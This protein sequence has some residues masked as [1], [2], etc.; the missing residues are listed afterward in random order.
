MNDYTATVRV[1]SGDI[2]E[3]RIRAVSANEARA[4]LVELMLDCG[5][6]PV[7]E[8]AQ[9]ILADEEPERYAGIDVNAPRCRCG[10][11]LTAA[12]LAAYPG[13]QAE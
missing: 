7:I 1:A 5:E 13:A 3:Q 9:A 12:H 4:Q 8:S 11:R 6:E 2:I 10:E